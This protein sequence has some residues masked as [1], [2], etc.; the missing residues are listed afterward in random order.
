MAYIIG[1][2]V[3][4]VLF[5]ALR[6]FTSF[7]VSQQLTIAGVLLFIISVAIFYNTYKDQESQKVR[8]A[9][10]KY[11]QG[12]TLL[13]DTREVNSSNYTLSIGTFTFIGKKGT[14][15]FEEMIGASNCE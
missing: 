2:F 15:Y 10:L 11:N 14:P 9:V 12:K 3:V 7:N 8:N 5:L 4:L 13:C 6:Y 1:I